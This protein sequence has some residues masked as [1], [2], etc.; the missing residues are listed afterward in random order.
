M[1]YFSLSLKTKDTLPE[2]IS[3]DSMMNVYISVYSAG[4]SRIYFKHVACRLLPDDLH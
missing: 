2:G 3:T 1:H 4:N